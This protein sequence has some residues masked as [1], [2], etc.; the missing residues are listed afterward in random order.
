MF[1][2][3]LMFDI[4]SKTIPFVQMENQYKELQSLQAERDQLRDQAAG[5]LTRDQILDQ[6]RK[7]RDEAI[8]RSVLTYGVF[9]LRF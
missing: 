8:T 5:T 2:V 1:R 3:L 6:A 7:E 9:T 4:S